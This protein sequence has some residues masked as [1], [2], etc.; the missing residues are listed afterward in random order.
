LYGL[1]T[2]KIIAAAA[3]P[4]VLLLVTVIVLVLG[5]FLHKR[6]GKENMKKAPGYNNKLLS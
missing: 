3:I 4:A 2:A 1:P 6:Q 5:Y